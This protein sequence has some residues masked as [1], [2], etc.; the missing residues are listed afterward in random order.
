MNRTQALL[1]SLL[2]DESGSNMIE[3]ALIAAFFALA[4]VAGE[5]RIGNEIANEFNTITSKF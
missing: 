5:A 1:G 4:A 3:Y 2:N